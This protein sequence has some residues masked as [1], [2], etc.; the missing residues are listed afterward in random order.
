MRQLGELLSFERP[1]IL[2][3]LPGF[4]L[5]PNPPE[6]GEAWGTEEYAECVVQHLRELGLLRCMLLGT[7]FG[8]RT[9]IR[10]SVKHPQ[11]LSALILLNSHGL[12]RSRTLTQ[13]AK[14]FRIKVLRKTI[15]TCDKVFGTSFYQ[16]WYIPR[17][18]SADY[19]NSRDL[20]RT[21]VK[22]VNED[23][24][25]PARKIAT[26][27]FLLWGEEDTE[28]PVEFCGRFKE[29]IPGVTNGGKVVV[30]PLAGHTFYMGSGAYTAAYHLEPWLRTISPV[31]SRASAA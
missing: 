30:L 8:G 26:P 19:R 18:A 6:S 16:S 27:T 2:V 13:R 20:R 25:I 31:K 1:V 9:G 14:N 21:L 3:D 15:A 11:F 22:T 7:S 5:S 4:G 29:L 28:T 12:R 17:F 10:I 24:T 23:L